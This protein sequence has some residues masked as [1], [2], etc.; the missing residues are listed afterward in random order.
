MRK[1][2]VSNLVSVDGFFEAPGQSLDWFSHGDDFFDY[3]VSMLD[4][5]DTILYGS[6][7]YKQMAA[8]WPTP[9]G[10]V[11]PAIQQRMNSLRKVVISNT[12]EKAEWENSVILN[13]NIATEV[14]KLKQQP[15]KNI[16]ILGSGEIVSALTHLRLIDEYRLLVNPVIL[17]AGTPLFKGVHNRLN[18]QLLQTKT[19]S[20]GTIILYYAPAA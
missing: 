14:N 13:G 12:L 9:Q 8:F 2:I 19:L 4:E 1:I 17:G 6:T 20:S 18:L 7:T 16:V 15:G 10:D 3:S 5:M 11:L